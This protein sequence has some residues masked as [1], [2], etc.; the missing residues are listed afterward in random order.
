MGLK[1]KPCTYSSSLPLG[2]QKEIGSDMAGKSL[3]LYVILR[4]I[5]SIND[6]KRLISF[7]MSGITCC[8]YTHS[9]YPSSPFFSPIN[10]FSS[11][12]RFSLRFNKSS[13]S[14]FSK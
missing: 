6:K 3:L 10:L 14:Q 13:K 1:T 4:R 9:L 7:S 8:L 5:V 2:N 12:I 11:K